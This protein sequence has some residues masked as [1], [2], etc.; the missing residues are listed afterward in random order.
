LIADAEVVEKRKPGETAI[1]K[2]EEKINGIKAL[3]LEDSCK[4][5]TVDAT[6]PL[7]EVLST[8]KTEIWQLL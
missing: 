5:V 2:L 7:L 8:V 6:R 4:V 3:R 1:E